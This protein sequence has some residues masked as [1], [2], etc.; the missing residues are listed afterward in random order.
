MTLWLTALLVWG[1]AGAR[2]GRVLVKPA[3]T[4]RVAIVV[5]VASVALATTVAVPEIAL[6]IDNPLPRGVHAGLLSDGIAVAA[7]QLFAVATSVVVAAAWPVV[8]R[9]NLRRI[10]TYIYGGGG[11]AAAGDSR[12]RRPRRRVGA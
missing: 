12:T 4:A 7:W 10:A 6:A 3:T 2:V 1:A 5:A 8:S 11:C 9:V